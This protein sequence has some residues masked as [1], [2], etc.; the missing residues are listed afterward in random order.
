MALKVDGDR[1]TQAS[2]K[3]GAADSGFGDWDDGPS[4][5][6]KAAASQSRATDDQFSQVSR[7]TGGIA[8]GLDVNF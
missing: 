3:G 5:S 7:Q 8:N 2:T 4:Q 1:A 6:S